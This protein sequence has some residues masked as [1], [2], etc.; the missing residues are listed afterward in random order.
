MQTD[1]KRYKKMLKRDFEEKME[2]D[3]K[4]KIDFKYINLKRF[5]FKTTLRNFINWKVDITNLFV[6]NLSKF[7]ENPLKLITAQQYI[8]SKTKTF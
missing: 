8:N 6:A 5:T 4:F 3:K 2:P 7:R 1:L